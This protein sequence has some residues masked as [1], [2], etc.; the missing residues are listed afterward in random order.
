MIISHDI[1]AFASIAIGFYGASLYIVDILKG[2]TKPHI[3]SWF[4]WGSLTIIAAA[5]QYTKGA[6]I[7]ALPT[8]VAALACFTITVLSLRYGEKT[9]TRSDKV[10]FAA[11][12]CAIPLW[13]I[14][15]DPL[16]SVLLVTA[17]DLTGFYPTFRKSW[18]KPQEETVKVFGLSI[19]NFGLL[20]F[21]IETLN[22][23]TVI[24]PLSLVITNA[25][26]VTFVLMRRRMIL[27]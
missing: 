7:G 15:A 21:A 5:G 17:I 12:L 2:R 13:Y 20:L 14:T 27:A 9:I 10:T 3:F 16:W 11:A 23:T 6:G 22:L 18:F 26:F 8:L 1:Y 25:A 4:I 19:L 24:Y